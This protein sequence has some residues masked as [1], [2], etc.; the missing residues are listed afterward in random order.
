[1]TVKKRV[2]SLPTYRLD[3]R[4]SVDYSSSDH[5]SSDDSSS[6]SS[7]ETSL[8]SSTHALF[9]FA[10]SHSSSDHSLPVSPSG[11]RPNH[12]LWTHIDTLGR[13]KLST[14]EKICLKHQHKVGEFIG[15]NV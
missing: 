9:D 4:H 12:H 7:S 1:M 6:S 15:L 2:G 3:V 5:F 14:S 10:S 11:T 8:D 13:P